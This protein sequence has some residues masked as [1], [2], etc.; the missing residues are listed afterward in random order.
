MPILELV[1]QGQAV[2]DE[3]IDVMGRATIEAV[4]ELSARQI[5]GEP[6]QGKRAGKGVANS[7]DGRRFGAPAPAC[8]RT[9]LR[10]QRQRPLGRGSRRCRQQGRGPPPPARTGIC[11]PNLGFLIAGTPDMC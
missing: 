1:T 10:R 7:R 5:A 4:L 3:A 8:P 11:S 9:R 6:H 2:V